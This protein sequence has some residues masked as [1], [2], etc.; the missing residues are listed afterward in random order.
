VAG[1][2]Y[3]VTDDDL[4]SKLGG[5]GGGVVDVKVARAPGGRSKGFA[6]VEM[7]DEGGATDAIAALDGE[8][9][10]GRVLLVERARRG[11]AG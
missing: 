11:P 8:T 3:I 9:W 10:N 2:N 5:F 7:V 4:R 6:F 1:I